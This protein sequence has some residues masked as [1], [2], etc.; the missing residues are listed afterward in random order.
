VEAVYGESDP[1]NTVGQLRE[2]LLAESADRDS[3]SFHLVYIG[4]NRPVLTGNCGPQ[5]SG[6]FHQRKAVMITKRGTAQ[7][8][9]LLLGGLLGGCV[10]EQVTPNPAD[11]A[12]AIEDVIEQVQQALADVQTALAGSHFPALKDVKLTLQTVATRKDNGALKLWVLSL[13]G[14]AE[15]SRTQQMVLTLVP[16]APDHPKMTLTVPLSADLEAA[17]LSAVEGVAKAGTGKVPLEASA[18]DVEIN[19]TVKTTGSGGANVAIA[20][21]TVG[22]GG[23]VTT[24]S[25]QTIRMSFAM[26]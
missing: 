24:A 18:L 4:V 12:V 15:R 19:F 20:P 16:P 26:K 10:T 17:I 6:H 21:V 22:V 8:L 2:K 7:I 13:G 23:E 11:Q 5:S 3:Q 9:S 25:V 14:T 1:T